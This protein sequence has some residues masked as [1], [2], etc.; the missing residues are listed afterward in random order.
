MFVSFCESNTGLPCLRPSRSVR[1]FTT[2]IRVSSVLSFLLGHGREQIGHVSPCAGRCG[3]VFVV[4]VVGTTKGERGGYS[5]PPP[6]RLLVEE[7]RS[8][9]ASHLLGS[10]GGNIIVGFNCSC[11]DIIGSIVLVSLTL[12]KGNDVHK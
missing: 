10:D 8:T 11:R 1:C 5:L 7:G 4:V 2:F 3:V 6:L 9:A 12:V